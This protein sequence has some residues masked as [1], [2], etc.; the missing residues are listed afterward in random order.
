MGARLAVITGILALIYGA[1]L[2]R[3]YDLQ[4]RHGET[5]VVRAES[6]TSG[7]LPADRGTVYFTDKNGKELAVATN[8]NLPRIFAIPKELDDPLEA[9]YEVAAAIGQPIADLLAQF[10]K[11]N[12]SYELIERRASDDDA[13]HVGNLEIKG[14]YVEEFPERVYPFSTLAAHVLGFV[15][16]SDKT[17]DDVGRYGLEAFDQD[18]LAG[19]PGE[20][21]DGHIVPPTPGEDVTLTIDPNIQLEAERLL[22]GLIQEHNAKAGTVIVEEPK[23]GRILAM[24]SNPTFDPNNYRDYKVE[25]FL[26]PAVQAIYEPGSVFKVITMAAGIDAGKITPQTTYNDTGVLIE[27]G[28]KIM[29]W[30]HKAYGLQTMTNVIEKSLNTGAAFAERTMGGT[31]FRKYLTAFGFGEKTGIDLPGEVAGDF[32]QLTSNAPNIVYATASYG[33]GVAVTTIELINAVSAIANGGLLMR[34]YIDATQKP[35]VIRRVISPETAAAVTGMMVSAVDKAVIARLDSYTL[36]GKTGT[37]FVPDFKTHTYTDQVINTY[38]G[39][40]PTSDP[41]FVILIRLDEPE[42]APLAGL[43]VVPAFRDLAQ[44]I[45]TY[46]DIP[47]DRAPAAPGPSTP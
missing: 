35:E 38:V 29:N 20:L 34:P 10:S 44:F 9:A 19:K 1:L 12:D 37:A 11:K 43:T 41:R 6:Q 47:P 5:Y 27:N 42:G 14:I 17:P 25:G 7:I 26:N 4:V 45:L 24:G 13:T 39:F 36:A 30:D 3:L 23:T 32:H 46:Y 18:R 22:A 40:G 2:F 28:A 16:P 15:G 31:I 21:K 8:K 33:Q